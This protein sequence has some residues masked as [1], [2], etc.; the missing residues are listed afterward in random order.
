VGVGCPETFCPV[1]FRRRLGLHRAGLADATVDSQEAALRT[2]GTRISSAREEESGPRVALLLGPRWPWRN[3]TGPPTTGPTHRPAAVN[4]W[5]GASSFVEE[6]DWLIPGVGGPSPPYSSATT[7]TGPA[8]SRCCIFLLAPGRAEL[9]LGCSSPLG[10][11][12]GMVYP[13]SQLGPSFRGR[14]PPGSR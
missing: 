12:A 2:P 11:G 14:P 3:N 9:E 6:F 1:T 13:S 8:G 4:P 5:P 7:D 10:G